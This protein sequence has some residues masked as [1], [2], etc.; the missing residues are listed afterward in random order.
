MVSVVDVEYWPLLAVT[1][2]E[3]VELFDEGV[4]NSTPVSLN[5]KPFGSSGDIDQL[6]TF[7]PVTVGD[8][9]II[10]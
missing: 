10:A 4:P 8:T 3:R 5:V 1:T 9:V 6:V 7:P 2:Y